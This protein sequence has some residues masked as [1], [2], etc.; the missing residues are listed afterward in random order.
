[1]QLR[2][3]FHRWRLAEPF[4]IARESIDEVP[5]L[6]AELRDRAGHR[7]R[8]EAVGIDYEGETWSLPSV[9]REH[10]AEHLARVVDAAQWSPY[11]RAAAYH[12]YRIT[13]AAPEVSP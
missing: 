1:M 5:V 10:A 9:L 12:L 3:T 4:V 7:G 13:A 11:A 6:Q 8:S 2:L